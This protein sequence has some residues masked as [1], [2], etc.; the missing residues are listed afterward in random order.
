MLCKS[1]S[2]RHLHE[3]DANDQGTTGDAWP[4]KE[5]LQEIAVQSCWLLSMGSTEKSNFRR[6]IAL[7]KH[8]REEEEEGAI[9]QKI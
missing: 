7:A 6:D 9:L 4:G 1:T 8:P 2:I 3:D 5:M